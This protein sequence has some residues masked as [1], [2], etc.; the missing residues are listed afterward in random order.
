MRCCD[1]V[2]LSPLKQLMEHLRDFKCEVDAVT[3]L[4]ENLLNITHQVCLC[5]DLQA[6]GIS[7]NHHKILDMLIYLVLSLSVLQPLEQSMIMLQ[8]LMN[9][10]IF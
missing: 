2:L 3:I 5:I 8:C 4:H 9:N 6:R 1:F 7:E 10:L